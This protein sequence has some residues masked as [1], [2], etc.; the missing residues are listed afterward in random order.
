MLRRLLSGPRVRG[1]ISLSGGTLISQLITLAALPLISRLY[2]PSEFGVLSLV[3]AISGIA[4]PALGLK[5]E[6]ATL[7]SSSK[8]QTR[9]IT[10]MAMLAV[11]L[12]STAWALLADV[13][14]IRMLG[15]APVPFLGLW[16]WVTSVLTGFFILFSQLALRDGQYGAVASRSMYQAAATSAAQ[17]GLG[18]LGAPQGLLFGSVA[19]RVVGLSGLVRAGRRY[20][21]RHRLAEIKIAM[22]EYWRFPLVFAPSA[23]L[24]SLGLQLPLL[25]MTWHY[26]IALGGQLGMAER[27]VA[28]PLALV[29]AAVGQV[30][31]GELS[32]MRRTG[33]RTYLRLFLRLTVTLV[34]LAIATLG[35]VYLLAPALI[36]LALG[37]EWVESAALVQILAATGVVRLITS[38]LTGAFAVFQRA[39]ANVVIDALRVVLMLAAIYVISSFSLTPHVS[40]WVLYG[41]LGLI[42]PVT[43][44]YLFFLLRHESRPVV[45]R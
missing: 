20:I 44:V 31:L 33:D 26:G 18:A 35:G 4:T 42:Y 19:G 12:V 7:L 40:A 1:F 32:Q 9:T 13:I 28:V 15:T 11:V 3:L 16:V 36:P 39:R 41:S 29:G 5:F 27:I 45:Q 34:F 37:T 2:S 24:N 8:R 30:F 10:S 38:P 25:V 21:G 17:V 23:I 22:R 43:W 6:S 14:A